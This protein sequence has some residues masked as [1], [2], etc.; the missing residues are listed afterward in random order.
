MRTVSISALEIGKFRKGP[1]NILFARPRNSER[2]DS[3]RID[4]NG[5]SLKTMQ[6]TD[7]RRMCS[8]S[9]AFHQ[10]AG[11]EVKAWSKGIDQRRFSN[12]GVTDKRHYLSLNQ[13]F[14]FIEALPIPGG[15]VDDRYSDRAIGIKQVEFFRVV[16]KVDL[17]HADDRLG[18]AVLNSNEVPIDQP[19]M[20]RRTHYRYDNPDN[21]DI[22]D[23]EPFDVWVIDV[24]AR[25]L[26]RS[27]FHANDGG[28]AADGTDG[29]FIANND[30][31]VALLDLDRL[32]SGFDDDIL[33]KNADDGC[34]SLV[35]G[36]FEHAAFPFESS[37]DPNIEVRCRVVGALFEVLG[38]LDKVVELL[39]LQ[40]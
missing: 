40:V 34:R 26:R 30:G 37:F 21:I 4:K 5:A 36:G 14:Q 2:A 39:G 29:D 3:R 28:V 15:A 35:G 6:G 24:G 11:I 8:A 1:L 12:A 16:E 9:V 32:V 13:G 19:R 18:S 25:K 22:R 33:S 38:L 10:R 17:V 27:C 20:K 7:R 23:D 31:A